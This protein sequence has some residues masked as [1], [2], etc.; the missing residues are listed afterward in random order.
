MRSRI[1]LILLIT[2]TIAWSQHDYK[3]QIKLNDIQS[4]D[5]KSTL[6]LVSTI[7]EPCTTT[8][9]PNGTFVF[10]A[11]HQIDSVSIFNQVSNLGF[12]VEFF[13]VLH[14]P[15]GKPSPQPAFEKSGTQDCSGATQVCSNTTFSGNSSGVGNQELNAANHGCLVDDE[16]Q[17]SWYYL[18]V[19]SSGSLGMTITPANGQDDY[20]FAIWG[21]YTPGSL[22]ANCPPLDHP[23][24]CNFTSYPD[25]F[26][27]TGFSCGTLTNPTGMQVNASLPTSSGSCTDEPYSRHLDVLA[28]EIYIMIID[29][30]STSTDPFDL[31]WNGTAVLDCDPIPLSVELNYFEVN[32]TEFG[33]KLNWETN[34]ERNNDYFEIQRRTNAKDWITIEK[35]SGMGESSFPTSY[36][37]LDNT[38]SPEVNYYRIKQ[39][40]FD[41]T[42]AYFSIETADNRLEK[43]KIV[44]CINLLGQQ[45]ELDAPCIRIIVYDD[46]TKKVILENQ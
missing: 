15:N 10:T 14:N 19:A 39:V 46:G 41:G 2:S 21:P 28:G 23:I 27:G 44:S 11:N 30:W 26:P 34:T 6:G 36:S 43:E 5:Y 13:D 45:V 40:D 12:S 17:S 18:Y 38:F 9:L 20:D 7:F 3:Y 42:F 16:R 29:N 8:H 24:R 33:N 31:T 32:I 37:Y 25:W 1:V 22:M 4:F 35:Q